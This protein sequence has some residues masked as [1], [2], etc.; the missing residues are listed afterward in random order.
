MEKIAAVMNVPGLGSLSRFRT[1]QGLGR[2]LHESSAAT[3]DCKVFLNRKGRTRHLELC[4]VK[5]AGI[6]NDCGIQEIRENF[7]FAKDR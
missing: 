6:V 5:V 4:P 2:R 3:I 1:G 7:K